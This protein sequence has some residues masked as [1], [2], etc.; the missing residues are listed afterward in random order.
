ML[1]LSRKG[2]ENIW[3][4]ETICITVLSIDRNKVRIGIVAPGDT[5]IHRQELIESELTA[6][7]RKIAYGHVA[8]VPKE[9][10]PGK[11]T[12]RDGDDRRV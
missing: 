2:G 8:G 3:I 5:P 9:A 10:Q 12:V 11:E 4:G 6:A 7:Q 1:V